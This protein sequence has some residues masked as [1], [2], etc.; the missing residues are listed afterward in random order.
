VAEAW[1]ERRHGE[2]LAVALGFSDGLYS[3]TL[4]YQHE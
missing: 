4:D 1:L 2:A 3:W